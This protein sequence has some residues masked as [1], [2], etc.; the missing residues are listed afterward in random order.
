MALGASRSYRFTSGIHWMEGSVGPT[1]G[2][3][4]FRNMK[5]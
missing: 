4:V 5:I 1:A 3:E 2:Q